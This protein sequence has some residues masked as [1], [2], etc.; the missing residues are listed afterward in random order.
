MK[1]NLLILF[2]IFLTIIVI[3]SYT[4]YNYRKILI[5]ANKTNKEY[6]NASESTILGSNLMSI[7]NKAI[8][9]N[10]KNEIPKDEKKSYT[11]NEENSI[12][13]EVKFLES[14][15]IYTMEAIAS[16]GSEAFIKNYR[17]MKFQ[18]SK[19]EYHAKTNYIKYMLFE[20]ID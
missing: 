3:L 16:L 11:Q 5:L 12:K 2:G 10:E 19:K 20:Q 17:N 18:C 4:Y 1:K 15:K 6:E 9:Q 13:I 14:D 7:I 8:D